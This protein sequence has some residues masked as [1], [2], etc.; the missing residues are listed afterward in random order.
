LDRLVYGS[1]ARKKQLAGLCLLLPMEQWEP[2]DLLTQGHQFPWCFRVKVAVPI[3][4]VGSGEHRV[5][6][7]ARKQ[8]LPQSNGAWSS[9]ETSEAEDH[10]N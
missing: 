5:P 7:C 1:V 4:G 3:V 10:E 2:W 9:A 8:D 6:L